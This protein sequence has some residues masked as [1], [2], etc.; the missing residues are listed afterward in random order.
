MDLV[1]MLQAVTQFH[2]KLDL[3]L[4][5]ASANK[6]ILEKLQIVLDVVVD[7]SRESAKLNEIQARLNKMVIDAEEPS[8][9][10]ST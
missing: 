7:Q 9:R 10:P 3:L 4:A 2:Q 8:F 5:T 1:T 6:K